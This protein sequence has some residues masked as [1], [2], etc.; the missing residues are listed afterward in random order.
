MPSYTQAN[1]PIKVT[2]PLGADVLLL[3]G[4]AGTEGISMP[5]ALSLDLLSE[6]NDVAGK[7]LLRKPITVTVKLASG[8]ERFFHGIA[9]R[10]MQFGREEKLT[11]YRMEV[12]PA[13][14]FL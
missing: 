13:F 4:F 8:E 6:H 10:F 1:R 7:D 12:V 14:W 11:A 2:T 5:F 9:S 3:A